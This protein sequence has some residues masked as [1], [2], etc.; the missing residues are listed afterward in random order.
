M[1]TLA[2]P[3]PCSASAPLAAPVR[4]WGRSALELHDRY[5]QSLGVA[6]ARAE[7]SG[8]SETPLPR[9]AGLYL[10][11]GPAC[12]ALLDFRRVLDV[13]GWMRPR[14]C[15]VRPVTPTAGGGEEPVDTLPVRCALTP[16]HEL[17]A[18]WRASGREGAGRDWRGIKRAAGKFCVARPRGR[19]M[20][21]RTAEQEESFLA[22]LARLWTD[23]SADLPEIKRLEKR[24]FGIGAAQD[25]ADGGG[26]PAG[27]LWLG[28]G[29]R[30]E[31]AQFT[32]P[33]CVLPDRT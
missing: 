5:W 6:V 11:I 12:A 22:R 28:R 26:A 9:D 16:H 23:P 7:E 24:V 29:R 17:A 18:A 10:L 25:A 31:E 14:L 13:M 27:P 1:T 21:L 20:H 33:S 4:L 2:T 30:R 19:V 32:G 15:V 8:A 3:E